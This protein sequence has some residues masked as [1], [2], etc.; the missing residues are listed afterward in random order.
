[1]P[2][3]PGLRGV[4]RPARRSKA[5]IDADLDAE[6]A[7]HLEMKTEA[8]VR[9]GLA[10]PAARAEALRQFGDVDRFARDCRALTA[11]GR[12]QLR[13]ELSAWTRY[14]EAVGKVLQPA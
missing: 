3:I 6:L 7:F 12:R 14:V 4:F 10:P 8:L 9:S 1:M 13:A 2:R 5:Q 11:A